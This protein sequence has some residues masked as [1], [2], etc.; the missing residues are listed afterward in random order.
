MNTP[1]IGVATTRRLLFNAAGEWSI[2]NASLSIQFRGSA[3]FHFRTTPHSLTLLLHPWSIG[4]S[5]SGFNGQRQY[6]S[7]DKS[8]AAPTSRGRKVDVGNYGDHSFFLGQKNGDVVIRS[9]AEAE[10]VIMRQCV[11]K[12]LN[13]PLGEMQPFMWDDAEEALKW[14]IYQGTEESVHVSLDLLQRLV[15]ESEKNYSAVYNLSSLFHDSMMISLISNWYE[16][17]KNVEIS[18]TPIRIIETLDRYSQQLPQVKGLAVT[19]NVISYCINGL[20]RRRNRPESVEMADQLLYHY[21]DRR[22]RESNLLIYLINCV[23]C[24]WSKS[25]RADAVQ[26]A[27]DIIA[28]VRAL[29]LGHNFD[30]ITYNTMLD[31]YAQA[32]YA[33]QAESLLEAMAKDWLQDPRRPCPDN[34][35][36]ATTAAAW[37]RSGHPQAPERCTQLLRRM[38]D[39]LDPLGQLGVVPN[40]S[41]FNNILTC[42]A[43]SGRKDSGDIANQ[44]L[45]EMKESDDNNLKPDSISY[46]AVIDAFGKTNNPH[47]AA[48][49]L[50][51][52]VHMY[53]E[54]HDDRLRPSTRLFSA[55]MLAWVKSDRPNRVEE[56]RAVFDGVRKLYREGILL[57]DADTWMY[58]TMISAILSSGEE[59][60]AKKAHDLLESMKYQSQSDESNT[61]PNEWSYSSVICAY[62]DVPGGVRVSEKLLLEAWNAGVALSLK[63][64]ARVIHAL[65][66]ADDPNAADVWLHRVFDRAEKSGFGHEIPSSGLLGG[67]MA[68]WFRAA[69]KHKD[70]GARAERSL[71]RMQNLYERGLAHEPDPL[72][73]RVLPKLWLYTRSRHCADH[74]YEVIRYMRRRADE[75]NLGMIP[76]ESLYGPV[77]YTYAVGGMPDRA[78]IVLG[79]MLNDY[80]NDN[81]RAKPN[82]EFFHYVL[83]G[84]LSTNNAIDSLARADALI[85]QMKEL[86][87][88]KRLDV[89]PNRRTYHF[90]MNIAEKYDDNGTKMK[91]YF[92]EMKQSF[93]AGNLDAKPSG[94]SYKFVILSLSRNGHPELAESY[95]REA[96]EEFQRGTLGFTPPSLWFDEVEQSWKMIRKQTFNTDSTTNGADSVTAPSHDAEAVERSI[97]DLRSLRD[98]IQVDSDEKIVINN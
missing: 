46:G 53:S 22:F 48:K 13:I 39:P 71:K 86:S 76:D 69:N 58:N 12:L 95:L 2:Q 96:C 15:R 77:A 82:T 20:L 94:L 70:A 56:S 8:G 25:G 57:Q 34:V 97:R 3:N 98:T 14:W 27:E 93:L 24:A 26:R 21:L 80:L 85:Q 91:A 47:G 62:L 73:Y 87:I 7:K 79:E 32:G 9:L 17:W 38:T 72:S 30:I 90:A 16:V 54:N 33:E 63:T 23:L 11:Q 37:A 74:A 88:S 6:H 64:P 31:V 84:L 18:W 36:F 51:E 52:L 43:R 81:Q 44:L 67:V 89:Q 75:G 78:E 83:L 65:A 4:N 1:F 92:D 29:H 42:W 66:K 5:G 35:S 55:I 45:T 50:S 28:K 61:A 49:V 40:T 19:G 59:H 10:T 60:R 41:L 68:A